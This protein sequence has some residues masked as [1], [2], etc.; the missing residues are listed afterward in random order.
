MWIIKINLMSNKK[1]NNLEGVNTKQFINNYSKYIKTLHL[2]LQ[3]YT[4][5]LLYLNMVIQT[6][7]MIYPGHYNTRNHSK[8]P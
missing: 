5:G 7:K 2:H 6:L 4:T 3:Q 1:L 8:T